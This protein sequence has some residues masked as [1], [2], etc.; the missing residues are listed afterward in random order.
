MSEFEAAVKQAAEQAIM[1]SVKQGDWININYAD[2]AK[3]PTSFMQQIW[4]LV[5]QEKLKTLLAER[6]EQELVDRIVNH[7][8]AELATD[9][10][11]IL[12]VKERREAIRSIARSHFDDIMKLQ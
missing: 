11:Q 5:D 9:I 7:I 3:L 2:R 12:S 4:D 1:K 10:K 8:A 6:L